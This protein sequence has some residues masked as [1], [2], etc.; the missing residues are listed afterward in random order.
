MHFKARVKAARRWLAR[1]TT[2]RADWFLVLLVAVVIG[3]AV[4]LEMASGSRFRQLAAEPVTKEIAP[5]A[6][7]GRILR[8]GEALAYDQSITSLAVQYRYLE[9]PA[10]PLWLRSQVRSRLPGR[11]RRDNNAHR[12]HGDQSPERTGRSA[13]RTAKA[14]RLKFV[15]V[16]L[17]GN[18]IQS[19]VRQLAEHVNRRRLGGWYEQQLADDA[20]EPLT[21]QRWPAVLASVL[22]AAR[23]TPA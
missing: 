1:A 5:P 6:T 2:D 4:Q 3:R 16:D 14:L 11:Q 17:Y 12:D 21:W 9:E 10:N 23:S 18:R 19:H 15:R 22:S 7:R 8:G 20:D 13:R